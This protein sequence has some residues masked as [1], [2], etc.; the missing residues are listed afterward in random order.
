[1]I[2]S[3][4][5]YL[6][7][8]A[9]AC[10]PDG[11]LANLWRIPFGSCHDSILS[12]NRVSG[13]SGVIQTLTNVPQI[14]ETSLW[15]IEHVHPTSIRGWLVIVLKRHCS[16]LHNVTPEELDEFSKLL[17]WTCRGMHEILDSEKEYVMQFAEG[18]GFHHVHFHVIARLK[19]WPTHFKGPNVFSGMGGQVEN[20]LSS[21]E[22]L[23][24]ATDLRKYLLSHFEG[25]R[26]Q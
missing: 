1:M 15:M 26:I 20:P 18:E 7:D 3:H 25:E 13:K 11:P 6:D 2:I 22:L 4:G 23:P 10:H 8:S 16:A 24:F 17:S 5:G 9:I 21:E 14:L 19:D 12:R